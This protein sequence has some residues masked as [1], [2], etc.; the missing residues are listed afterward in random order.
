MLRGVLDVKLN[1]AYG[2]DLVAQARVRQEL[3]EKLM[4]VVYPKEKS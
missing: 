1:V 2:T 3:G 4:E